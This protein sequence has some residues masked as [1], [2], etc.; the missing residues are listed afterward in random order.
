MARV[1]F[2]ITIITVICKILGFIKNS[3][4]AYYFG[5]NPVVDAYVMTFS[6]GTITCGWIAGFVGNF[7][8]VF[9]KVEYHQGL[10]NA[11]NFANNIHNCI[12]LLV[13][14]LVI[15]LE[16]FAPLV[17]K[18][19]APGFD[20]ITYNYT[21]CFFRLYLISVLFYASYR[22]FNEF[23][24]CNQ[25]YIFAS[26]P[27]VLMSSCC[28]LAIIVSS[29]MGEEFL[30]YGYVIAMIMEC[31]LVNIGGYKTGFRRK[32]ELKWDENIKA[33]IVMAIPIFLSNTLAEINTLIDKVF[34]STLEPGIV[35]S[36]EYA[37]T[38]KEFM[39]QIGTFAMITIIFPVLSKHWANGE[40]VIFKDKVIKGI[41]L[42]TVIYMP[43]IA[44]VILV[45]DIVISIVFKRGEFRDEAAIITTNGFII[46]SV[47]LIALALRSV[48]LKAFYSMQKTR[49]I[50]L[51]SSV[52]VV[53]NVVMNYLLVKRYGY[54][55][56][57]TSTTLAALLCL[58]LYFWLFKRV[59][60]IV[61]Y[62]NSFVIFGKS[63]ISS[64][65]MYAVLWLLRWNVFNGKESLWSEL[66]MLMI[67]VSLGILVYVFMG[68]LLKI[69]EVKDIV[70][71]S[72]SVIFRR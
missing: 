62:Y 54:I 31:F 12:L 7:T 21:V 68:Y 13:L 48:F 6:I 2:I 34:A 35:A 71:Y 19:V 1:I 25:K 45:G 9:K 32:F 27:D 20:A 53:L 17:V 39:F 49:Y 70:I 61:M 14:I 40:I 15:T 18:I 57:A 29:F 58:P 56:L 65:V 50:L 28:I 64:A 23:L 41:N 59:I 36:L 67:I 72:R 4:L 55:G 44:G 69:R 11:L 51:V 24:N 16:L 46:Y 30:I 5:T 33:V 38:M 22:F 37:N 47:G 26:Y 52:N 63:L 3:V 8:P 10:K 43:L 66:W 60:P 42:L